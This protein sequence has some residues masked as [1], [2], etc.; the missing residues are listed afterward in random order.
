MMSEPEPRTRR[1]L[2]SQFG[3]AA[4]GVAL[5]QVAGA[6]W[7][8]EPLPTLKEQTPTEQNLAPYGTMLGK[9]FPTAEGAIAFRTPVVASWRQHIFDPGKG[10]EDEIVWVEYKITDPVISR[11]EQH[12]LTEQA[13]VPLTGSIVQILAL[14]GADGKPDPS[15]LRAFRLEPG[16]GVCMARGVWHT[17]RSRLSTCLMLTRGST[18]V[19]ILDHLAGKPLLETT[20]ENIPPVRLAEPI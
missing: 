17:T 6:A 1:E 13:V 9:P 3:K 4:A 11:L 15:T 19:D 8:A 12:M 7:A 10:G 5:Y 2:L 20:N 16:V 14:S 18:S